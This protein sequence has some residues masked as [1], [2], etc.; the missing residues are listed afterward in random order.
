MVKQPPSPP[1]ASSPAPFAH[2]FSLSW[3]VLPDESILSEGSKRI[4]SLVSRTLQ[5]VSNASPFRDSSAMHVMNGFVEPN[6]PRVQA[7][8]SELER[9][10][11]G[12]K[13][14]WGNDQLLNENEE[15]EVCG[16]PH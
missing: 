8:F 2:P 11:E 10:P 7:F 13:L 4:L 5:A 1:T 6:I 15:A 16:A 9:L 3:G 14:Q 12:A